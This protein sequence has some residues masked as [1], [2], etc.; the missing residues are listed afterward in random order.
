MSANT[1]PS[2]FDAHW[3]ATIPVWSHALGSWNFSVSRRPFQSSELELHYDKAADVWQSKIEKLGF[4][5]AYHKLIASALQHVNLGDN[6]SP[7]QVLDAGIGT[8]AMSV[9]LSNLVSCDVDLLGVDLSKKMLDRAKQSIRKPQINLQT[10]QADLSELPLEDNSFDVVLM[11]HVVEHLAAPAA[12][13]NELRRVLKPG[14]VMIACITRRSTFGRY[15]QYIWRTHQV[16]SNM[17]LGWMEKS[18]FTDPR[19]L[20][21]DKRSGTRRRSIGYLARK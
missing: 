20:P 2:H 4:V 15:I 18:G 5:D 6:G 19:I 13:L 16:D 3:Q 14:G 9:A 7:L 1:T 11:A 21:L 10:L 17:A 12:V 8:G